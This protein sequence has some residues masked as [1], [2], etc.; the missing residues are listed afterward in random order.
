MTPATPQQSVCTLFLDRAP[1][2]NPCHNVWLDKSQTSKITTPT[3]KNLSL[4]VQFTASP[5]PLDPFPLILCWLQMAIQVEDLPDCFI[6]LQ[7]GI[8]LLSENLSQRSCQSNHNILFFPSKSPPEYRNH[9]VYPLRNHYIALSE[10]KVMRVWEVIFTE[11]NK[12]IGNS[13]FE[14]ILAIALFNQRKRQMQST[15]L[16]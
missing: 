4:K 2:P 1:S 6:V 3:L 12:I 16:G 14:K 9:I 15:Q 7:G 8:S 10:A 13:V 11:K 5:S